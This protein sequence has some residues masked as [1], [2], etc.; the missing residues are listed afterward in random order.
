MT[1]GIGR[2]NDVENNGPNENNCRF[3]YPQPLNN[4]GTCMK[5]REYVSGSDGNAPEF[6]YELS[7]NS[8]RNDR[9][10]N[11]HMHG[12]MQIWLANMDFQLVVDV[13]KV[14]NYMTKY[15]CKPEMEMSKGLSK[16]VEK[17]INV[18]YHT[19]IGPRGI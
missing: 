13:N 10:L 12:L 3:D 17:L 15:V 1:V 11:S 19:G 2:K 4:N 14:V 8:I 9:W 7:M 5:I 6:K 18:G 16:M